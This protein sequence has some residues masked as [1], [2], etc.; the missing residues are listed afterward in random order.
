ME[1]RCMFF[2]YHPYNDIP[3]IVYNSDNI[4]ICLCCPPWILW[5]NDVILWTCEHECEHV[6]MIEF[7][8]IFFDD[9]DN[10]FLEYSFP[11]KI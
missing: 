7:F 9:M 5:D 8:K 10:I 1:Q 2:V 11:H 3:K 6:K 4:S